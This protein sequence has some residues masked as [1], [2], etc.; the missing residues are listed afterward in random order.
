MPK[1]RTNKISCHNFNS[2]IEIALEVLG[3][4]WKV[5]LLL[6]LY[7]HKT[8][9]FNEFRKLIPN[10]SQKMLTQQLRDLEDNCLIY[11]TVYPQVPPMVEYGLTDLAK[12]L[13][14]I[15]KSMENW[16]KLYLEKY[17]DLHAETDT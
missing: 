15:L 16:G 12:S 4:K 6:N 2:E 11:R 5:L 9:R 14:P 8:I 17:N 13:I 10:I 1:D 7:E 3:G